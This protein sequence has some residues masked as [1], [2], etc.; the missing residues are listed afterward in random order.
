METARRQISIEARVPVSFD[1]MWPLQSE[2]S[3]IRGLGSV[4]VPIRGLAAAK[5]RLDTEIVTTVR[6]A[7]GSSVTLSLEAVSAGG[8]A[9]VAAECLLPAPQ[10][11]DPLL[12]ALLG[13]RAIDWTRLLMHGTGSPA[14][15]DIAR[16]AS[17]W[18]DNLDRILGLWRELPAGAESALWRCAADPSAFDAF[19]GWI[20]FLTFN[21]PPDEVRAELHRRAGAPGWVSS[22]AAEWLQASAGLP[23]PLIGG[24]ASISRLRI[25]AEL[26]AA[27]L[28]AGLGSS[29]LSALHRLA[30]AGC[31]RERLCPA[32]HA[33]IASRRRH[34]S[35]LSALCREIQAEAQSAAATACSGRLAMCLDPQTPQ[36]PLAEAAFDL[37]DGT[38][39]SRFQRALAGDMAAF[40][41]ARG[42]VPSASLLNLAAQAPLSIAL[43]LPI[44][45][46]RK[47]PVFVP[48]LAGATIR[49]LG[50]QLEVR[51]PPATGRSLSAGIALLEN[52]FLAPF[53]A[54]AREPGCAEPELVFEDSFAADEAAP[55]C[56]LRSLLSWLD[57]P[58]PASLPPYRS[59][60]L[61]IAI[62]Q[63]WTEIWC[64]LPHAR[65]DAFSPV[66]SSTAASIQ[67]AMRRWLPHLCLKSIDAYADPL[68]ALPL[69]AYA[70]SDPPECHDRQRL[71][72]PVPGAAGIRRILESAAQRF[73]SLLESVHE[74]L[75][76]AGHRS[77]RSY[78]PGKASTLLANVYRQR[79]AIS[80][81]L[82]GDSFLVQEVF[83]IA[84][85]AGVLRSH[86]ASP[87]A[88][89]RVFFKSA[90]SAQTAIPRC[91][92]RRFGA[93]CSD[94]LPAIM[95]VEATA[96]ACR[97]MGA[98]A[99]VSASLALSSDRGVIH[100]HNHAALGLR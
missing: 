49:N 26:A 58:V 61:R 37:S 81:L 19:A 70:A 36:W 39:A 22:P 80:R 18:P 35:S 41:P 23:L 87:K 27:L 21:P 97:A 31:L 54:A 46:R 4:R 73:P 59:A 71:A 86:S 53:R 3:E 28:D 7:E 92:R 9:A 20:D 47:T 79:G 34:A 33:S 11:E 98:I 52:T 100:F 15:A 60:R 10:R 96:A 75:L 77:H 56:H 88:A 32:L 67:T 72:R 55:D 43:R 44:F 48:L 85:L 40:E 62:P 2:L 29:L 24:P 38:A 84:D 8:A 45:P 66:F 5:Y 89:S 13:N 68:A 42:V 14:W 57:I 94:A 91:Y 16:A 25:A 78:N 82:A 64:D 99:P 17:V 12:D 74:P 95:L 93:G 69:L 50:T 51:L 1:L 83:N 76:K 6:P 90:E 30:E 65:D 63:A